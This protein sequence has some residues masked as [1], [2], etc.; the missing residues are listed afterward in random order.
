MGSL[1]K[2]MAQKTAGKSTAVNEHW[3]V[4]ELQISHLKKKC[5][6]IIHT[7]LK[8][9][10]QTFHSSKQYSED[11]K[12]FVVCFMS[13]LLLFCTFYKMWFLLSELEIEARCEMQLP[14]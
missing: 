4:P 7:T 9:K 11:L 8:Y 14:A 6:Q 12:V 13:F 2:L 10:T 5:S 1:L 3:V